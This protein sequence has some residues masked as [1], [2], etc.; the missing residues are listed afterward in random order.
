[1]GYR[2]VPTDQCSE[3]A[4]LPTPRTSGSARWSPKPV[5]CRFQLKIRQPAPHTFHRSTNEQCQSFQPI[6]CLAASCA[7]EP[8]FR[9]SLQRKY[10][11]LACW[12]SLSLK[13]SWPCNYS[14]APAMATPN[15]ELQG[16]LDR[17]KRRSSLP[18]GA[19]PVRSL[20]SARFSAF[21][22][23]LPSLTATPAF[24]PPAPGS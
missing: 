8:A 16:H 1:M 18:G 23:L 5:Q 17:A 14:N 7:S 10:F 19:L 21:R 11:H 12:A 24:S 4:P 22:L 13:S 15:K 9:L 3:A 6:N 20:A 2:L